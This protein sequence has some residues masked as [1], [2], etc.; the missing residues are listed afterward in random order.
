MARPFKNLIKKMPHESQQRIKE[1][2]NDLYEEMALH[3][4]RKAFDLTQQKVAE[5]LRINQ[6]AISKLEKQQDMYISTLR[7]F[8]DAMGGELRIIAHFPDIDIQINQFD[9]GGRRKGSVGLSNKDSR[10]LGAN[11]T[12]I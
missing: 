10:A 2:T 5:V 9:G 1:R 11:Q 4:L 3:E 6:A 12:Q 7:R 8:L